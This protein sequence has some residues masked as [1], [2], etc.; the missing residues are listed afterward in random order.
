[1]DPVRE[2]A[3]SNLSTPTDHDKNPADISQG[4][5]VFTH[6]PLLVTLEFK[7]I[8]RKFLSCTH[9]SL[10]LHSSITQ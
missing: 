5:Y 1:M 10:R 7:E 4:F 3:G 6:S 9:S 8:T 2:V